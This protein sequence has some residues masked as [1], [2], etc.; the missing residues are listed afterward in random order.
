MLHDIKRYHYWNHTHFAADRN[1]SLFTYWKD[2]GTCASA[3]IRCPKG[4]IS[5]LTHLVSDT[6]QTVV[7]SCDLFKIHLSTAYFNWFSACFS[8]LAKFGV[9]TRLFAVCLRVLLKAVDKPVRE[10]FLIE[11][12][13]AVTLV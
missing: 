2:T 13:I 7:I 12:S 1:V 11:I 4:L 3:I 9:P 5:T 10:V 8:P 6:E